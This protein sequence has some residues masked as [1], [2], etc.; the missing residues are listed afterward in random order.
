MQARLTTAKLSITRRRLRFLIRAVGLLV[1]S[2][3]IA[4]GFIAGSQ[5]DAAQYDPNLFAVGA[6]TLFAIACVALATLTLRNRLLRRKARRLGDRI[7]EL[8]DRNWELREAEER[9]RSLLEAQG[10][11]IVR[12]DAAGRITYANDAFCALAGM[13]REALLG[14]RLRHPGAGARAGIAPARRHAHARPEDRHRRRPALDRLARGRRCAP[15]RGSE[16][17]SVGRD[18]TDRVE[19]E[20]A[21]ARGARSS[22]GGQPRQVA[23]PR[24]GVSTRSAR[25]STACSA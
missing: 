13:P 23:L 25:R 20:R 21:L 1:V 16:M 2:F 22:G 8:A 10:D 19:A 3:S 9:A 24:H 11:V 6:A 4:F 7:E 15:R 18:V 14:K 12:R 5:A 17:Q